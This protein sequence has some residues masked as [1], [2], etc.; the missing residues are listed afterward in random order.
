MRV[1]SSW[2]T[3]RNINVNMETISPATL[4]EILQKYYLEVRKQDGSDY[5]PD[6]LKVMQA[7]LERYLSDKKYP[8]SLIT[9]RE[10]AT[11][12]AVL[13]AKA[14]Q[15]RMNGYGKRQNRA[16]PYNSAQ[17]ELFWSSGLLGDHSGVALTNTNF[18][19]LSEH[20]GCRGRQD[21][22][23]AYVEDFEVVC[24]QIE[25][26]E[27]AKCVRFSENPTKTRTGGL[28]AKHRKTPQEMWA[29]DGGSRDPVRLFQEFLRRRLSE[30]RTS[31]PLYLTIIQRP[32]TEVWY[33]KSKM[34]EHKLGSIMRT[35]AKTLN[36]EGKR[37]S[38][39]STRKSV[40]AKLKK[41]GQP[42][43][44]IIQITDHANECS[45]DDYDEVDEGEMRALSHIISGYTTTSTT[46]R[47]SETPPGSSSLSVPP[48]SAVV[49]LPSNAS[50]LSSAA[51][52]PLP[53]HQTSLFSSQMP[54]SRSTND[55]AA[56]HFNNCTVN[57]QNYFGPQSTNQASSSRVECQIGEIPRSPSVSVRKRR[58][59]Y[60]LDSDEN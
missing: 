52:V 53:T 2:A 3:S 49:V 18:K 47:S 12:R 16:Q 57:I 23:D 50:P 21:Q 17:E 34:G 45:L 25:G 19:N 35:L 58:R 51:A 43:H 15:L 56:Q 38:N 11:S 46:T 13:D 31:G 20:C 59:A 5:E 54:V 6:S 60:T 8:N 48:T 42:R 33:A 14:Q 27:M 22:H 37:I 7:A 29:T 41:A 44:K 55:P 36:V 26:G 1:G 24:I 40:V 9:G 10:F 32:K 39:H 28:T 30:M 4:D